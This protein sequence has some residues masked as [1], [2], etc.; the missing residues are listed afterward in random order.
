MIYAFDTETELAQPGI[1]TPELVC[2]SVADAETARTLDAETAYAWFRDA[3]RTPGVR[4]VGAWIP[5]DFGVMAA[6]DPE[7]IDDIFRMY[8]EGR[9]DDVLLNEAL[10]AIGGGHLFV[11]PRTGFD[12][13]DPETGKTSKR[14]KLSIVADIRLN[15]KVQKKDTWRKRY[16]L[17]K[18]KPISEWPA[19]AIE[20]PKTDVRTT[21]DILM[22][23]LRGGPNMSATIRRH[24]NRTSWAL[25]LA[26]IWGIR[27]SAP[28][29]AKVRAGVEYT[30]KKQ[31]GRFREL[32]FLRED[33][34]EDQS[35]VRRAVARVYGAK[36]PCPSCAGTCKG[37]SA[38]TGKP[39]VCVSCSGTGLDTSGIY[40]PRTDPSQKFPNGQISMARDTLVEC[41]DDVLEDYGEVSNTSKLR[42]TY[43]PF[44]ESGTR[45]PINL[46]ANTI[47]ATGR[48][49][50]DGLI[51]LLPRG[52][53]IR[54]CFVARD[55]YLYCSVDYS[56]L[57]LCTLAQVHINMFGR[58]ALADAINRGEDLHTKLAASM[59]NVPYE[60]LLKRVEVLKDPLAKAMRQMA[61]A[62]NFGFPGGM[63]APKV[64]FTS[65]KDGTRFCELAGI[66]KKCGRVK[67]MEYGRDLNNEPRRIPP[68]CEACIKVA[69]KLREGWFRQW[70][71]MKPYFKKVADEVKKL[72]RVESYGNGMIRGG[73]GFTD[74]ANHRFQNLA[75]QGATHA[76]WLVSKE[77]YTDRGSPLF[78][79]RPI[80]FIHDEIFSELRRE[81]AHEA[82]LRKSEIMVRA[83]KIY[84]PDVNI[85]AP[86]ALAEYWYK[87][88]EP[89]YDAQKRLVPWQPSGCKECK[90]DG[91][92][93]DCS[94]TC[95][96]QSYPRLEAA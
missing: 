63:G 87:G 71:E 92:G 23:Q 11:D 16:G 52:A 45:I 89:V 8:D 82:A 86:P 2:G 69:E 9:V 90:A 40:V 6:R 21:F 85:K 74:G 42:D 48:V 44:L 62:A 94:P 25:H 70:P 95:S 38:K 36:N 43:L 88:M 81:H 59:N 66:E 61:K 53:R 30:W 22:D 49:S 26:G 65:R 33:G 78:G 4:L 19:D 3:V 37:K 80:A 29:V 79:S 13:R 96:K 1:A 7:V 31:E 35:A 72:G 32:G 15:L 93:K 83:M 28:R 75:A 20:Y 24:V 12:M 27:T 46:S 64:V 10:Q 47:V 41:G 14:Y 68:T 73:V 58:S 91:W 17:L 60:E 50:Y 56:A 57:E 84:C 67:V 55:G 77:C 76:L 34:S 18:N 54:E 39:I 51:Q 5:Y